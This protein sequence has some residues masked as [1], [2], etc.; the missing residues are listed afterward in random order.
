MASIQSVTARQ[1]LDSRG[2]PTV[3]VDV[4]TEEGVLGRAAVP[5]GASTGEYEA[6]E[7]R[8]EDEDRF[9]G[10]GVTKAVANVNTTLAP[11]LRGMNVLEQVAI[12]RTILE[13]DGT[14]DKSNLGANALLGVSLAAA[15]AA[16]AT[17]GLPLFRYVGTATA[18]TLPVPLM[19][20]LN[21][22]EH[23]DNNVDMQEFMIAPVGPSSFAEALRVGVEV[24]HTLSDVLH[25]R[26]YSTTVGDEGGF[27]P[28]LR[29]NEEAIELVVE[30]IEKAGYTAGQDVFVALDPA[31]AEMYED[32]QYV[33]WKSAPD[34]PRSSDEMVDYWANWV[35]QY[36]ILSIEDAM[37][38]DDWEGWRLLT[39]TVGEEV[40]L[41]GDDLFVTNTERLGRG[42]DEGCANSILVKPNQIGTLTETLEAVEMAH[43][44]GFTAILSHRSG[45][46]EDTTIADLAVGLGTGQI[47][48]GSASRSDRVAK[49]NQLLRIEEQL[50]ET[51]HYPGLDAFPLTT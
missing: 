29:S 22:G 50:G 23:A 44:S 28:D 35:D 2:N 36:P 31:T 15:K 46:T 19:N 12:D 38:E 5:S 48:T 45:E 17:L 43:K 14:P 10:K 42:I 18:A 21:G 16:A 30:A 34:S 47:K 37:D 25:A 6:V 27:A 4:T 49:Y 3:E 40:Q 41:V 24:F 33:F 13:L 39:D 51:A 11:E 9:D 20:I 8:D 32:G 7:L 26:D 1:I